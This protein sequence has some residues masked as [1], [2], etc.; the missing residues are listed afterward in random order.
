MAISKIMWRRKYKSEIDLCYLILKQN[1][2]EIKSSKTIIY[3]PSLNQV[4]F[5]EFIVNNTNWL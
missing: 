4:F 3:L 2:I 5:I 1:I